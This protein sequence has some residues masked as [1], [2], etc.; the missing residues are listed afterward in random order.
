MQTEENNKEETAMSIPR[1]FA[2]S[3]GRVVRLHFTCRAEL[4]IG[5]LLRVTGSS[6]WAPPAMGTP[7]DPMNAHHIA[8]EEQRE[9]FPTGGGGG[10]AVDESLEY[11]FRHPTSLYTS[12]VE[13]VT[14]PETYPE[15]KTAK[16]VVVVLH[17][18][19]G[20]LQHHYYRYLVVTPGANAVNDSNGEE[21]EDAMDVATGNEMSSVAASV[22]MWEQPYPQ[23]PGPVASS[24]SLGTSKSGSVAANQDSPANTIQQLASLPYRTLNI[25]VET[26]QVVYNFGGD[27]SD[28][29]ERIDTWN[30]PEDLTFQAYQ[31]RESMSQSEKEKNRRSQESSQSSLSSGLGMDESGSGVLS[32]KTMA[33]KILFICFHLPVVVVKI[34]GQWQATW[35]ESLL[36]HKEGSKIVAAYRAHWIGTVTPHPPI[37]NEEDREAVRKVLANLN[38]TP[39]FLEASVR[40]AHYYGFCKQ[41]LW[42]AF[43]NIDLLDLSGSEVS[44][45]QDNIGQHAAASDWDQSRLD[46]WW[47]AYQQVNRD[48]AQVV[49][50]LVDSDASTYLWIHDYH[51][52]LLPRMLDREPAKSCRKVFFLHIPFPTSQIFRELECGEEILRGMLHADVVGFHAFDHA[53]H[54]LN[55]SKRILGLNNES[56]EGGLIGVNFLGRTVLV[57]MSNVSIEPRMVDVALA[58][59]V[60]QQGS[61]ELRQKHG[62][63]CIICGVEVAQRLS[64]TSLKLLAYERL[65]QDY[66]SWRS[67]VVMVQR[68]LIP[69]GRKKDEQITLQEV[70][71]I[72]HRIQDKF[73]LDVIDYKEVAGATLPMDQRLA[74]WKASDILMLTPIREGLN[75]W[76]MEFVYCKDSQNPGVVI[77]SE[78]TAVSSILNGALRVNPFDI[79]MTI[80]TIDKALSMDYEEKEGRRY[81]DLD[82]VSNCPSDK[83]VRNVLRD[84]N[85][86]TNSSSRGKSSTNT[87][88]SATPTTPSWT[89]RRNKQEQ[90]D[91]TA[92]FLLKESHA[93]FT[94]LTSKV[95]KQAYDASNRRVIMLDF[96]GTIVQKEPPGKYLK[97]E[98]L[99]T[100]GNKPPP[101][102][103][104]ALTLLCNDPKNTVYVVSGDSAE[105]V[106][107]ALGHIP[108][109]G[110]AVSNGATFS[111]PSPN[112]NTPRRWQ[113]FDLGVDW[114]AVKRVALPVLS[115]YTA[116]SNGSFVKLTTFSIGWSYYSCDP[117]WGSLQASHLVLEL[118]S[119]LKAFDVRFVTLKGIVEIVPRKLNKGL[120]VKKVL[121]DIS[122]ESV[123][124]GIDFC[125]CLGDDISDEKMFTSVFSFIA[126]MGHE[127]SAH[128]DPPV[129]NEDGSLDTPPDWSML[130]TKVSEP[131]YCYTCAV[132]KKPS[133]ASMY[134][135]DAKE[136]AD[137]LVLLVNSEHTSRS[138]PKH[139]GWFS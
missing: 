66:P 89:P 130:Q 90:L 21:K 34:N 20:A 131:M 91:G 125:M 67:R 18:T 54:F 51:L 124:Q 19:S 71:A 55:A 84:L 16:P 48:F 120:V 1:P 132:G 108:N 37:S 114:D 2:V 11:W 85:D 92:A 82:F 69:G 134:M 8:Q 45:S 53:R 5:S 139:G 117:E 105:N 64:G 10:D 102:V 86:V 88:S 4:P 97:R 40:Q 129:I 9:A 73:G 23:V 33:P 133:H 43:H 56:I 98:I 75:H 6:L 27:A 47:Q 112:V 100:S 83:W 52:S 138:E 80:T 32:K 39:I 93:S 57:S 116:R 118:E 107:S 128:P 13:M 25:N 126:E 28:P 122:R 61:Q 58:L 31:I 110:L 99:G 46:H 127:E 104:D 63:R 109:L 59:P 50:T 113:K 106:L 7:S 101:K 29:N 115:K 72:V 119:E 41:V 44:S 49:N 3:T 87:S 137:A 79:Q 17:P 22:M 68:I 136:V 30:N 36:A 26:A 60:V 95:L 103:I 123:D 12:S 24:V 121:R 74:L 111:A 35:S 135:T 42:P 15:W 62:Q 76:P 38:C 94:H 78:F 14:T 81:R 96:N 65:L 77:S 70:R